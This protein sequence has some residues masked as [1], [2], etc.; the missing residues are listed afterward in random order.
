MHL[1]DLVPSLATCRALAAAGFP[2]DTVHFFAREA[3]EGGAM[4]LD[5]LE[6]QSITPEHGECAAPTLAEVL[7]VLPET[8]EIDGAD[9]DQSERMP[10]DIPW[11]V[12]P[13]GGDTLVSYDTEHSEGHANAAEACPGS[14]QSAAARPAS[15]RG[16]RQ[17]RAQ[18][19]A[20]D[21]EAAPFCVQRAARQLLR[22]ARQRC[23]ADSQRVRTGIVARR[24]GCGPVGHGREGPGGAADSPRADQDTITV[25][26]QGFICR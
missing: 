21:P 19:H 7:A 15:R 11:I 18:E 9:A 22:P 6:Y 25:H 12:L 23:G 20:A 16:A 14:R 5:T 17:G 13:D 26:R 8:I 24:A 10:F 2:Q 4:Y 3:E 1:S